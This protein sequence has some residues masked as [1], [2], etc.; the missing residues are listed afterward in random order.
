MIKFDW[1]ARGGTVFETNGLEL[2]LNNYLIKS[3]TPNDYNLH[4]ETI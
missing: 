1:A 2:R 4:T 3:L